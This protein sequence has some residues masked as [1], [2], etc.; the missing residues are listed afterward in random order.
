M[1]ALIPAGVLSEMG[2]KFEGLDADRHIL[3]TVQLSTSLEG[4]ARLYRLVA[5]YCYYGEVI[6]TRA[7]SDLNCFAT[8]SKKGSFEE[9]LVILTGTAHQIPAF[10]DAYKTALDWLIAK[11]MGY[12]KDRL[13]GQGNVNELAEIIKKQ[14]EHDADLQTL[15]ANGLIKSHDKLADL[16]EQ[17]INTLP[18]LVES[19]TP[20]MRKALRPIGKSC[21]QLTQFA[22]Q[23]TPV[24]IT[25]AEAL[26]IRSD[27]ELTVGQPDIYNIIRFHSLSL[28]TGA[29]RIELEG[30]EGL[31]SGKV[32]DIAVKQPGN[33]YSNALHLHESIRVRARAVYKTD[34]IHQLFIT[35][36][37]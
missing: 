1:P 18:A 7:H 11:V 4:N 36:P 13:S 31:V 34:D 30:V 27:D 2:L 28:D 5:H 3:E 17:L 14:A 37:A 33:V 9:T 23:Q 16:H 8:P 20:S 12:I 10:A 22:D 6:R 29:C 32:V 24:V 26:A 25:E 19:A 15:L 35:E 21:S